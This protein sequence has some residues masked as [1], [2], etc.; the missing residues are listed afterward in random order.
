MNVLAIA[1]SLRGASLNRRLLEASAQ[2]APAGMTIDVYRDLAAIPVFSEDLEPG[3]DAV[4]TLRRRVAEADGLLIATPE[5]NQSIPGGLK[6]ALDWLSRDDVLAGKPVAIIGASSGRWGTRLAQAAVRQ[7]LAATES[8]AMPAPALYLR[9]AG[10]L[11][12][13]HGLA[14]ATTRESLAALLAAFARFIRRA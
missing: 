8:L 6:N 4:R 9:E 11:F 7:V 14:D 1:G 10:K 2:C 12:D 3:P 13:E 5:Y